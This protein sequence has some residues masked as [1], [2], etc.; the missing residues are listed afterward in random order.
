MWGIVTNMTGVMSVPDNG[1][2]LYCP[3]VITICSFTQ[4]LSLLL[5]SLAEALNSNSGK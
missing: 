3:V 1:K 5:N 2:S 4:V